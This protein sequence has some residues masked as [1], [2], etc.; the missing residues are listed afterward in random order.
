M[1]NEHFD[2]Y[3]TLADEIGERFTPFAFR[4]QCDSQACADVRESDVYAIAQNDTVRAIAKWIRDNYALDT[5]P[6]KGRN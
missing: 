2:P 1:T 4:C 6:A 3:L 5:V